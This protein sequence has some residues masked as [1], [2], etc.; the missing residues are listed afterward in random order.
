MSRWDGSTTSFTIRCS[1]KAGSYEL[2][3]N[4]IPLAQ[5]YLSPFLNYQKRSGGA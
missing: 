5:L 2:D 4:N 3:F 1:R